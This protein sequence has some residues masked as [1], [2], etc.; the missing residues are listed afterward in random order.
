MDFYTR[1]RVRTDMDVDGQMGGRE[2]VEAL[3][4]AGCPRSR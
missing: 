4:G 3:V 2:L 1:L